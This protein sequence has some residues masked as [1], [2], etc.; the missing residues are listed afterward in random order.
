MRSDT[1]NRISG[2]AVRMAQVMVW[3][4][5][6]ALVIM[7]FVITAETLVR[8]FAGFSLG[9]VTEISSYLFAISSAWA[10]GWALVEGAHIRI[11]MLRDAC[12]PRARSVLDVFAWFV[13]LIVFGAIAYRATELAWESYMTNARA[14]TPNRTQLFI[15]QALWA[16]GMVVTTLAGVLLGL[17]ALR[18]RSTQALS[19]TDEVEAELE[20]LK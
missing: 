13:F 19:P 16:F 12:R 8:K 9:G 6:G 3:V 20:H 10:L 4:A 14:P 2:F 15:P 1:E 11:T 7:S 18:S 5:G 17:Q